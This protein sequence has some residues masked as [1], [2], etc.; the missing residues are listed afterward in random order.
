[1]KDSKYIK[2][3]KNIRNINI[4]RYYNIFKMLKLT[5]DIKNIVYK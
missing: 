4:I 3:T 1:M 2:V 5:Q